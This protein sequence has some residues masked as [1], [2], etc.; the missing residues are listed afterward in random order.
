MASPLGEP[1]RKEA[2]R[3]SSPPPEAGVGG[4]KRMEWCPYQVSASHRKLWTTLG[5]I[6]TASPGAM[7]SAQPGR[8]HRSVPCSASTSS[9]SSPWTLG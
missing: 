3:H 9:Y 5:G 1:E 2:G 7:V 8:L 6:S 4:R